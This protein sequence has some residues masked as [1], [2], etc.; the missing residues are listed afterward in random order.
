MESLCCNIEQDTYPLLST[1]ST[2]EDPSGHVWYI[3]DWDVKY[4]NKQ[5]NIHQHQ[6]R[7]SAF[8]HFNELC[9]SYIVP[10]HEVNKTEQWHF[11]RQVIAFLC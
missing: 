9:L 11:K 10:S 2:Q 1:G 3:A 4:Q 5:T 7:V 6:S 8:I